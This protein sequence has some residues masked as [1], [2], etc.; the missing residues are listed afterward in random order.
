[1]AV[2]SFS[3]LCAMWFLA[4]LTVSHCNLGRRPGETLESEMGEISLPLEHSFELD[5]S[6]QYKHR[7]NLL[8]RASRDNLLTLSQMQLTEEERNKLRD[9]A[10]LDG[11]YRIRIPRRVGNSEFTSE[12]VTS[13]AR[14]C[15]MVESHLSDLITVNADTG[16]NII[17]VSIVTFPGSCNG[18]EVEDVDLELFNTTVQLVQPVTAA[19][20]CT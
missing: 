8:W 11:F 1:M 16:G 7:G 20:G 18:A 14:A 19:V 12:Y 3:R 15:S 9:V 2:P 5:N 17:G 4:F 10:N 6:V 13:F